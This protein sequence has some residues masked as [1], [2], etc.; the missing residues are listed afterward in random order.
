MNVTTPLTLSDA[1]LVTPLRIDETIAV[2]GLGYVGLPV[3]IGCARHF[4][5]V[6]GFDINSKRVN[7]LNCGYDNTMEI[8]KGEISRSRLEI[9]DAPEDLSNT[10]FFIVTVP[11]PID[12]GNRPDLAPL[13]AACRTIAPF[14]NKGDIVVFES[15]V[16]PGVT[17]DIC[18]PILEDI[19]GLACGTDFNLGYS[20][21]RIN[22]GDN[23][24]RLETITKVVAAQ[25]EKS[26]QRV[27]GVYG[28][29]VH[30]GIHQAPNIRV[31]EAAKV[32]ENTQRDV[33]IALMNEIAIICERLNIQTNDVLKAASTKWN[34]LP[35][36]PGLVGGHCIGVDHII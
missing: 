24:H 8:E 20:P 33:N 11:T 15:T 13:R 2:I 3:A 6:T 30:A 28:S 9:T 5:N 4:A 34:F 35:F 22:P 25:D 18:G 19:S 27:A 31:A 36:S 29:L 1:Q 14:L 23:E 16:Y 10:S 32:I 17:E 12:R 26:L 21:E 7:E